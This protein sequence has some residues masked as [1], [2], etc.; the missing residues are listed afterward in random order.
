MVR[1]AA[2]GHRGAG[3]APRKHLSRG[4][5]CSKPEAE[6]AWRVPDHPGRSGINQGGKEVE[7]DVR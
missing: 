5:P 6:D 7:V 1:K 3:R 4:K 2:S